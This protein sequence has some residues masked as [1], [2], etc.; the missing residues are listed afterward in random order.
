MKNKYKDLNYQEIFDFRK[1]ISDA[2]K[3]RKDTENILKKFSIPTDQ[4]KK[5]NFKI[6]KI[7][8]EIKR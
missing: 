2:T 7:K 3:V 4:Y 6:R 1:V 8:Y 5:T